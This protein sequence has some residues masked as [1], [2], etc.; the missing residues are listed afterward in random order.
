MNFHHNLQLE[1]TLKTQK[2]GSR[3]KPLSRRIILASQSPQRRAL[4]E[5]LDLVFEVVPANIDERA[6]RRTDYGEQVKAVAKAK[7]EHVWRELGDETAI[8]IAADTFITLGSETLEKPS[9]LVE[10]REMLHKLSGRT[11][12]A[13]TGLF[14]R[15]L[16]H[17]LDVSLAVETQMNFRVLS[18][19]E[20]EHYVTTQ[21]VT[22]WSAGFCPAYAEGASL[23]ASIS[24]SLTSFSHGFPMEEVVPLLTQSQVFAPDKT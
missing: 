19:R 18:E 9:D 15:D 12:Q 21:P 11:S 22:T 7:G 23:V 14:Y 10:A 3:M 17:N 16:E 4:M 20:I 13:L 5:T 8:V 2:Q 1:L 6:I 24:G